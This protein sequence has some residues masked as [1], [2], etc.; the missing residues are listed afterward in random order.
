MAN[1]YIDD[2]ANDDWT[3][4]KLKFKNYDKGRYILNDSHYVLGVETKF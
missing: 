3:K 2:N 1:P 4:L